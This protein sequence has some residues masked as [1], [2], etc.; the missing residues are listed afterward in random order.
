[1]HELMKAGEPVQVIFSMVCRQFRLLKKIKMLLKEGYNQ[2]SISKLLG[3]H[4]Y[5]VKN[6][7]RQIDKFND[8]LLTEILDRCSTIDYKMKSTSIDARLA[9]ETLLVECSFIL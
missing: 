4:P 3:L 8:A 6:V 7:M 2:T 5:V 1:M 9:I